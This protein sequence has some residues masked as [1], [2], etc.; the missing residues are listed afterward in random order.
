M[1]T[2]LPPIISKPGILD[3]CGLLECKPQYLSELDAS[4]IV[5]QTL[6]AP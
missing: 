5:L 2:L 1:V 4:S 6:I 3:F